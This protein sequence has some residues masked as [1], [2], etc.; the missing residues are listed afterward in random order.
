VNGIELTVFAIAMAVIL[1]AARRYIGDW[2]KAAIAAA[3]CAPAIYLALAGTTQLLTNDEMGITDGLLRFGPVIV[4][5]WASAALRTTLLF[6]V[7]L[8]KVLCV[9]GISADTIIGVLKGALWLGTFALLLA[10]GLQLAAYVRLRVGAL[11]AF[12]VFICLALLLPTNALALKIFNYDALSLTLPVLGL[13]L[14]MRANAEHRLGLAYA[15]VAAAA[16]GAQEKLNA[17]VV[18]LVA[19]GWAGLLA[20]RMSGYRLIPTVRTVLLAFLLAGAIVIGSAALFLMTWP[21]TIPAHAW[22]SA[23]N[24][25]V[26]W[27]WLPLRFVFRRERVGLIERA[28]VTVL[29]IGHHVSEASDAA[30]DNCQPTC[31]CL[32]GRHRLAL[33][34]RRNEQH[35][36]AVQDAAHLL[37]F[38]PAVEA[39]AALQVRG[40]D[41]SFHR[42]ALWPVADDLVSPRH[43]ANGR[44]PSNP[45]H[46]VFLDRNSADGDD[47]GRALLGVLR[48]RPVRKVD[49]VED[50]PRL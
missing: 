10:I 28:E 46:E 12:V 2:V 39:H 5:T 26:S 34:E 21:G 24:P 17:A 49:A 32:N 13:V 6:A 3:L 16:L 19:I 14:L 4:Q 29:S 35:V 20:G 44:E 47:G 45:E 27:T 50:D 37:G 18:L 9:L 8:S 36:G 48:R 1:G 42:C 22:Q 33:I 40:R 7:P 15:G 43:V 41:C 30:A 38:D 23:L 11:S 25:L 31:G